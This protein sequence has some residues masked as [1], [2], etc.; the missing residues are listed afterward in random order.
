MSASYATT[1][2]EISFGEELAGGRGAAEA[3][4]AALRPLA[5]CPLLVDLVLID[6][7][8]EPAPGLGRGPDGLPRQFPVEFFAITGARLKPRPPGE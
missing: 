6:S 5:P 8:L 7:V 4:A 1:G 2:W 3:L